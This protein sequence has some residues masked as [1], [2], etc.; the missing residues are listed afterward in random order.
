[1]KNMYKYIYM[2]QRMWVFPH[3]YV[4]Y[5]YIYIF[6]YS[7]IHDIY[8]HQSNCYAAGLLGSSSISFVLKL[9]LSG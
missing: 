9:Q 8:V 5:I 1:M 3:I 7:H 2:F 6:I 4:L